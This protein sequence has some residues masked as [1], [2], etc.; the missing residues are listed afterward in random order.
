MI[1]S[2]MDPSI[3]KE[4]K[5]ELDRIIKMPTKG[6]KIEEVVIIAEQL[7]EKLQIGKSSV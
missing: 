6:E 7:I 5:P 2:E 3:I 4:L 1:V